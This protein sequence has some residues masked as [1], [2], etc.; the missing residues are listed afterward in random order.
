[1]PFSFDAQDNVYYAAPHESFKKIMVYKFTPDFK[2]IWKKELDFS[3]EFSFYFPLSQLPTDD[4]GILLNCF[5]KLNAIQNLRIYKISS[6]GTVVSSTQ[7]P[8]AMS[9]A[10]GPFAFPNPTTGPL[11][12]TPEYAEMTTQAQLSTIDGRDVGFFT[13]QNGQIDLSAQPAGV[14]TLTLWDVRQRRVVG[15]QIVVKE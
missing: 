11:T 6:D 12:L 9:A 10:E 3:N 5:E 15:S 1:M 7:L 14:Y 2:P 4:G 13:V 8:G